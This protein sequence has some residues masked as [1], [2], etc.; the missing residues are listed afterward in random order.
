MVSPFKILVQTV[1][2]WIDDGGPQWSASIAYY[3]V[4]SLTPLLI[5]VSALAG[6]AFEGS[7]VAAVEQQLTLVLGERGTEFALALMEDATLPD[8]DFPGLVG[9]LV[10]LAIGATIVVSNIQN[11][12]NKIW[13]LRW[14]KGGVVRGAIHKRLMAFAMIAVTGLIMLLSMGL[15]TVTQ[16]MSDQVG[17]AI[18]TPWL[19]STLDVGGSVL[20]LALLFAATFRILPDGDVHW[21]DALLGAGVTAALFVVGKL[22]VSLYLTRATVVGV[23][24]VAGSLVFFL[25][26]VYYSAAIFFLGAVF[27]QVWACAHGR[28]IE[29]NN[30][31]VRV[32]ERRVEV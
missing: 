5:L 4:L 16:L 9:S 11:A 3:A 30:G 22:V 27:T 28:L 15:S 7:S 18:G 32:E 23:Y 20:I 21:K 24:G 10:I 1:E 13:G 2:T 12:L 14:V 26:W 17:S 29:P 19:I 25:I 6:L 31:A 8:R